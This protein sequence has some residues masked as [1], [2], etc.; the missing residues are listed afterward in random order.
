MH[1]ETSPAAGTGARA[2]FL[3]GDFFFVFFLVPDFRRVGEGTS[4]TPRAQQ[5]QRMCLVSGTIGTATGRCRPDDNRQLRA[6]VGTSIS[7]YAMKAEQSVV[8]T[9]L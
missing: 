9:N 5:H 7:D 4:T 8:I 6:A 3:A 1:F 2:V